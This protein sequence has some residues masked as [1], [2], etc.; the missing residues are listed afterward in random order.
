MRDGVPQP[1]PLLLLLTAGHHAWTAADYCLLAHGG[2]GDLLRTGGE[3]SEGSDA[4]D[5]GGGA[6]GVRAGASEHDRAPLLARGGSDFVAT[7]TDELLAIAN[8]SDFLASASCRGQSNATA[9]NAS[10]VADPCASPAT[11]AE[12]ALGCLT[13]MHPNWLDERTSVCL[14]SSRSDDE[15]YLYLDDGRRPPP[16]YRTRRPTFLRLAP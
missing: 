6:R 11:R 9:A 15:P 16:Y 5:A 4:G 1:G 8:E 12:C 7:M 10:D 14:R 13:R 3:G 2:L